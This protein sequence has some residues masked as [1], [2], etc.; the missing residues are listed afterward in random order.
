M[1]VGEHLFKFLLGIYLRKELLRHR[2]CM[3]SAV[4]DSKKQYYKVTAPI[5][6]PTSRTEEF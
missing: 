2:I 5:C 6:P 1:S 3:C 4:V